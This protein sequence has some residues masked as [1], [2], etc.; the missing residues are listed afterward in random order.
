MIIIRCNISFNIGT[1]HLFRCIQLYNIF[2]TANKIIII[3]ADDEIIEKYLFLLKNIKNIIY[4]KNDEEIPLLKKF[5]LNWEKNILILDLKDTSEEY[6]LD[7]KKIGFLISGFDDIGAGRYFLDLLIDANIHYEPS[8]PE[9]L[10][11]KDY[12]FLSPV[13][14]EYNSKQKKIRAAVRKILFFFGGSDP[15]GIGRFIIENINEFR[16]NNLELFF[17]THLNVT[18]NYHKNNLHFIKPNLTPKQLAEYYFFSDAAFISGGITLYETMCVGIPSV[19]INQSE[20]QQR[21]VLFYEKYILNAGI[22]NKD[23]AI[24]LLNTA[25]KKISSEKYR[26]NISEESKKNIDGKGYLRIIEAVKKL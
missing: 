25:F 12:I 14:A 15:A 26:K 8:S 2:D 17:F 10:F 3:R 7:L 9:R 4:K 21:N 23:T 1:G 16:F 11:G 13:F 18:E 22:F 5:F 6:V 24:N 19:V 20:E